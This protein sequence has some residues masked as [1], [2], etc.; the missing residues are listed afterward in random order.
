M[1][2]TTLRVARASVLAF[3]VAG[4]GAHVAGQATARPSVDK[5]LAARKW[6]VPRTP[7]GHP[8]LQGVW[9]N[10]TTTPLERPAEFGGREF[11]TDE[12]LAARTIE[13][14]TR[15]EKRPDS[16]VADVEL[17]YNNEWW[18]R[19]APLKRTSLILDPP[20]GKLPA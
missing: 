1:G 9:D 15:A 20:D 18:D 17:A 2:S 13:V 4:M 14:A 10:G 16:A 5:S 6:V 12:E 19:G 3:V 8:D 7:W 11:L